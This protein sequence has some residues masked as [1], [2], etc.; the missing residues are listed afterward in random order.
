[1][2]Y[3]KMLR[4]QG[5]VAQFDTLFQELTVWQTMA[6]GAML[7]MSTRLTTLEKM[8]RAWKL[9][10]ELGLREVANSKV[11]GDS[12]SASG[13]VERTEGIS[14]GQRRLL[15]IGLVLLS[16]PEVVFADEPTSGMWM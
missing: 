14:G 1:M 12:S 13:G 8:V 3:D 7:Q 11:G 10:S 2:K 9:V 16:Q 15:S 6:Y 5:F 4:R